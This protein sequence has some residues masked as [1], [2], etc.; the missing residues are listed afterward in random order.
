MDGDTYK[1]NHIIGLIAIYTSI[2]EGRVVDINELQ[3]IKMHA[4]SAEIRYT[5]GF[6]FL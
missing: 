6:D 2:L 3:S 4:L 5:G 1:I